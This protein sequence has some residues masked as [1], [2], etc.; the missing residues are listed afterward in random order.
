MLPADLPEELQNV[1]VDADRGGDGYGVLSL[2][3]PSG[4]V[5]ESYVH[6]NDVGTL[7]AAPEPPYEASEVFEATSEE[8]VELGDGTG[9]TLRYMVQKE[10]AMVNQAPSGRAPSRGRATPTS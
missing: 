5:V 2:Y 6:A 7:V 9:A 3:R 1:A 10:G 8:T 4:H